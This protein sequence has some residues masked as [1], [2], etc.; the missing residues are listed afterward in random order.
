MASLELAE[1]TRFSDEENS[2]PRVYPE[3]KL[4]KKEVEEK[5]TSTNQMPSVFQTQVVG[6]E[7]AQIPRFSDGED[8]YDKACIA[9]RELISFSCSCVNADPCLEHELPGA[10]EC[11]FMHVNGQVE[12]SPH[13]YFEKVAFKKEVFSTILLKGQVEETSVFEDLCILHALTNVIGRLAAMSILRA[14]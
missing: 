12:A 3:G 5:P 8:S 10:L 9:Y 1:I 14:L 6:A 2:Y 11:T 7:L 13:K 4:D